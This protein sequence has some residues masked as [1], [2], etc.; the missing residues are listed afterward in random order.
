MEIPKSIHNLE[1]EKS[2]LSTINT[3]IQTSSSKSII[4]TPPKSKDVNPFTI[5][6]TPR[7][8]ISANKNATPLRHQKSPKTLMMEDVT[9]SLQNASLNT[10]INPQSINQKRK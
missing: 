3:T 8:E 7:T 9:T 4:G 1:E 10:T 6:Q 5:P 2:G